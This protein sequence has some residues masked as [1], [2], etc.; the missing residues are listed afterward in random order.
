MI[1]QKS[2]TI[3]PDEDTHNGAQ[4]SAITGLPFKPN[5]TTLGAEGNLQIIANHEPKPTTKH[6]IAVFPKDVQFST[7]R[8]R[9][10]P[11]V[12]EKNTLIN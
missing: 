9:K 2:D 1:T 12:G 3:I 5:E 11:M 6:Y 8:G 7:Q 4:S 10:I